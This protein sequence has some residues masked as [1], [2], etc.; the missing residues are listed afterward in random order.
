MKTDIRGCSTCPNGQENYEE[1]EARRGKSYVQYDY[2]DHD[3]T[4]FSCV[5][6]TLAACREARD[7]WQAKRKARR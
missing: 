1:F 6:K 3:G 5:K 4:L 2:R 7:E